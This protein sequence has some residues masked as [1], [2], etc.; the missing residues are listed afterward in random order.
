[1][2]RQSDVP[3]R[4]T[5]VHTKILDLLLSVAFDHPLSEK[6]IQEECANQEKE[7]RDDQRMEAKGILIGSR[8]KIPYVDP[9]TTEERQLAAKEIIRGLLS[10][11]VEGYQANDLEKLHYTVEPLGQKDFVKVEVDLSKGTMKKK[12]VIWALNIRGYRPKDTSDKRRVETWVCE[13]VSDPL[14]FESVETKMAEILETLR[15]SGNDTDIYPY[16]RDTAPAV[17]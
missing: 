8:A 13:L 15:F 2:D 14:G 16:L 12:S 10:K 7:D 5:S 6:Q 17:Q 1:M 3:D 9:L 4:K 11:G